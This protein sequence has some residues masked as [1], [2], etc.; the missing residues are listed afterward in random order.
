LEVFAEQFFDLRRFEITLLIISILVID[1]KL[2]LMTFRGL[3][4]F[5]E[6][7]L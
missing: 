2:K 6:C 5:I 7:G 4:L 3:W 1:Y